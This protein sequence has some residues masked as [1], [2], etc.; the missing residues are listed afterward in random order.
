MANEELTLSKAAGVALTTLGCKVSWAWESTAG[1]RPT[2]FAIIHDCTKSLPLGGSPD[3]LDTTPLIAKKFKTNVSG[4]QDV[5]DSTL[6]CNWTQ[7]VIDMHAA[8]LAYAA[9][10]RADGKRLWIC[11]DIEGLDK[12]FY[13][14]TFPS[15]E[16]IDALEPNTAPKYVINLDIVGDLEK[17]ADPTYANDEAG[18]KTKW[19]YDVSAGTSS[20]AAGS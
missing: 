2:E 8:W 20:F 6:E 7:A 15:S 19:Q 12:S 4:L 18:T 3:K 5:G 17:A 1:T 9:K 10:A 16:N 13:V 14:P 11:V